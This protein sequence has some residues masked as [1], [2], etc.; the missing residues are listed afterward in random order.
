M[1][2]NIF[3]FP[4]K[5][6]AGCGNFYARS[7]FIEMKFLWRLKVIWIFLTV[8]W[9]WKFFFTWNK[10]KDKIENQEKRIEKESL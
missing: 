10:K 1:S 2:P 7:E 9:N 8:I 6:V 4:N 5:F 3:L